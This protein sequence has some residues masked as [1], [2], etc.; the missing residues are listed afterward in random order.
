MAVS[1]EDTIDAFGCGNKRVYIVPGIVLFSSSEMRKE[2]NIVCSGSAGLI[3]VCLN[4]CKY[5][6]VMISASHAVNNFS[7]AVLKKRGG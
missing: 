6:L 5:L 1:V 2:E 3:S 7:V 4:D